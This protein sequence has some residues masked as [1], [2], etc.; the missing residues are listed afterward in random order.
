MYAY[1]VHTDIKELALFGEDTISVHNWVFNLGRRGDLYNG[2]MIARQLD[3]RVGFAYNIK[4]TGTVIRGSYAR[5]METPFNENLILSSKGCTDPVINAIMSSTA[6][7]CVTP[8]VPLSPAPAMSSMQ[9]LK[10]AFGKYL[11]IEREY[12]WKW[13]QRAFDFSIL[14]DS[15]I[16]FPMGWTKSK[17]PGYAIRISVPN[18]HGFTAYTVKP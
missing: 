18:I 16:T 15:P 9:G 8:F 12:I 13:T 1:D 4:K 2:I 17:I 7:P 10:R 11:V 5:T 3:P 14:G 6:A